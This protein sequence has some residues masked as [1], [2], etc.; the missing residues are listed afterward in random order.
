MRISTPCLLTFL[1]VSTFG[2]GGS[3]DNGNVAD[4]GQKNDG[5]SMAD[6]APVADAS[7]TDAVVSMDT[8]LKTDTAASTDT[9]TAAH[10]CTSTPARTDAGVSPPGADAGA[11]T[12]CHNLANCAAEVPFTDAT[13]SAPT[14][15]GGA[16]PSGLHVLTAVRIYGL[17]GMG[18]VG[19][20]KQRA[21]QLWTGTTVETVLRVGAMDATTTMTVSVSGTNLTKAFTCPVVG[22]MARPYTTTATGW[23]DFDISSQRTVVYEYSRVQ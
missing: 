16:I 10:T 22:S 5:A 17:G 20:P 19:Q 1:I 3:S 15:A 2:C 6:G 12:V 9:A 7:S 21:T 13:G 14:P 23:L 11:G 18:S 8:A 4:G